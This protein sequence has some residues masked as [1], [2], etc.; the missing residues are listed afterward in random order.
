MLIFRVL[1]AFTIATPALAMSG[2]AAPAPQ[3]EDRS[4][5]R[6]HAKGE[7]EENSCFGQGRSTFASNQGYT[8]DLLKVRRGDNPE[9]NERWIEMYC[10]FDE[11]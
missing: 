1:L 9:S 4:Q 8:G 2:H 11:D 5:D 7:G 3:N 10:D 6:H